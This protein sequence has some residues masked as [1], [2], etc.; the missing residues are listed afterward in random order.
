MRAST[1]LL[2]GFV[3]RDGVAIR[4]EVHGDGEPT[5]LLIPSAPITHS[6]IWK[7]QTPYLARHYR[8]VTLDGRGN[9]GSG[10]PTDPSEHNTH[11]VL[12][13]IA[14]VLDAT[15]TPAAVL[16]AHCH[17]NW[18]AVEFAA[19]N[20]EQVRAM[21]AIEPGVPYLGRPQPH[22][23]ETAPHWDE[24]LDDPTGWELNNRHAIVN[25]HRDWIEFFFGQQ[26]VE[27]YSTKQYEDAVGWALES[28]GEVL[29]AADEG[30][31]LGLPD[32]G[33]VE[34]R[35]RALGIPTLTIHGDRD[36][37]QHV[38]RG[39]VFAEITDGEL[40]VIEGGG[41]LALARDPVK[42]NRTIKGFVDRITG[43]GMRSTTWT[44]A[45]DRKRKVLYL[46]SP[47]GLGHAR[48]DVA[49]VKEL[50][51]L[52]PD[53]HV[54]WLAQ[55]PV[56][57]V[58]R[59]EGESIHPASEWLVSESAHIAS[60]STGH[61]LH[62]FQA[63]RRMDE[64][65]V[66]NFMVFQEVVEEGD[67][68]LVVGDEA[69]DVDH[70]WHENPELK[71]GSHVWL[72]DFVGFIPMP[73]GGEHEAF[74]TADY[75]AE[76]IEH[77]ARFPRIRDRAIFVG[78]RDDVIP[79]TFG[80]GL[81]KIP[82]WTEEHFDFSG[83][84][85]GFTPP[86]AAEAEE[87]R[88]EIG[89]RPDEKVCVVAVGGSGVGRDLLQEGH[90]RLPDGQGEDPRV[91]H[92]G[93][94]RSPD[95]PRQPAP[96]RGGRD[97]RLRRSP[98]SQPVG[99]RPRRRAGRADD[100]HGADR[101]QTAVPLLPPA[102]PLRA[103]LS[104]P[105]P[106]RPVWGGTRH[107]VRRDRSRRPRRGHHGRGRETGRVRRRGNRRR[108]TRRT[109]DR[110]ADLAARRRRPEMSLRTSIYQRSVD[111]PTN[112]QSIF[113]DKEES[114]HMTTTA[115][116]NGV[117]TGALFGALDAVKAQPEAARF[118]FRA[119]NRWVSGT[120]SQG[121]IYG[122]YRARRGADPPGVAYL[123]RRPSRQLV[124]Q[125]TG[126]T[127]AE[128]LLHALAA[129]ITAGIG[130]IAAVR[131][132]ELRSVEST[133]SGDVD[134]LGLLGLDDS[135]RNGYQG[136]QVRLAHRGR[137]L[138]RGPAC[139]R[140]ALGRPVGGV[141]RGDQRDSGVPRDRDELRTGTSVWPGPLPATPRQVSGGTHEP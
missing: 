84:I 40:V 11:V 68:D 117:D 38:D 5:L 91:A 78:S 17:A 104:R 24:V 69:W 123:R 1:T 48:R 122:F 16:V 2:D 67:Y 112:T 35:C 116:T 72:T 19:A 20:P 76:M 102:Q 26:L 30:F 108:R 111:R 23:V 53:L 82:D 66:A 79:E 141:R 14:A 73:S 65:L 80:P 94:G 135:V 42:V 77:I 57:A 105:T 110:R 101:R 41:H 37:C 97:P 29:A 60:E 86:T 100:D 75:N 34:E 95:R 114:V 56:T 3:D 85:T 87:W 136:I 137:R 31:G 74:L 12:G 46:S 10:R 139:G 8:V 88:S 58:L 39:R 124:A 15:S 70:Y 113:S 54:D 121:T 93:G 52:H 50:K 109:D 47:I 51:R 89:Y 131:G 62:C 4:Y 61:E 99:L 118:Q 129:C 71:R 128:F 9:G 27:P 59:A 49:I 92:G 45:L 55:H 127:P 44:R 106:A 138:G 126:P 90:L 115:M 103:E 28:T 32:K 13:D 43:E 132:I 125:D 18:W 119:T 120:H 134:L 36:I 140:G 6:R 98:L 83:Y 7:A 63:L 21:I 81:P 64:I 133:V 130:N 96:A 33:T 107:G 25:R 22:W